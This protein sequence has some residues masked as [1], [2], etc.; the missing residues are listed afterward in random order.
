MKEDNKVAML[1]QQEKE[2]TFSLP[3]SAIF[4]PQDPVLH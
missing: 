2:G 4:F 1:E 3:L